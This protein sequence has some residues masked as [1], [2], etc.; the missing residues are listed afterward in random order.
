M[1]EG[2][3]LRELEVALVEFPE[4]VE[5]GGPRVLGRVSDPQIV[6]TVRAAL[7]AERRRDLA[8][9]QSPVHLVDEDDET[10]RGR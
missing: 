9:L 10:D 1:A 6:E 7:A 2:K 3:N 4:G 8:R 5:A